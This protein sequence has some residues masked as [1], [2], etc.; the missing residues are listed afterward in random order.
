MGGE[1][2]GGQTQ[3]GGGG[4]VGGSDGGGSD[5]GSGSDGGGGEG[6]SDE[7][8]CDEG[9][10]ESG[11]SGRVLAF[12]GDRAKERREVYVCKAT[13]CE[14]FRLVHAERGLMHILTARVIHEVEGP[15][16]QIAC[17]AWSAG[18]LIKQ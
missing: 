11:G 13:K 8:S 18:A 15:R 14:Q 12:W 17:G 9:G 3:K 2:R 10:G 6:G 16:P 5:E 7:G 4:G 1:A